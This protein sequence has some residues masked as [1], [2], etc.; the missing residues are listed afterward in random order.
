MVAAAGLPTHAGK[1]GKDAFHRV[2]M[3]LTDII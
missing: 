2:S 3:I 1:E